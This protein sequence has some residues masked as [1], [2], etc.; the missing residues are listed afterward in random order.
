MWSAFYFQEHFDIST[1]KMMP[2]SPVVSYWSTNVMSAIHIYL[3]FALTNPLKNIFEMSS[4][5]EI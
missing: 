5:Q 4:L 1:S 2:I 3:D